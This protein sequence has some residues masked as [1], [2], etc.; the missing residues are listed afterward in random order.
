MQIYGCVRCGSKH[1]FASQAQGR[2][3][4]HCGAVLVYHGEETSAWGEHP[5]LKDY[6]AEAP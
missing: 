5:G 4:D 6:D 3:C 1:D 2:L